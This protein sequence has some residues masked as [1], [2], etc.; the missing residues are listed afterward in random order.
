MARSR[1]KKKESVD[2]YY[3]IRETFLT[4][5]F[6][7]S[8]TVINK[9]RPFTFNDSDLSDVK[10]MCFNAMIEHVGDLY[11]GKVHNEGLLK[12]E[13]KIICRK[14]ILQAI[15]IKEKFEQDDLKNA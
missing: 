8:I 11:L 15:E 3:L 13:L 6:K 7:R 14:T 4:R 9:T 10:K 12:T 5:L 2:S 1:K